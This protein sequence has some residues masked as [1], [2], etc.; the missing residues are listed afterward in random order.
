MLERKA[1][2]L[3]GYDLDDEKE[4]DDDYYDE[5]EDTD[6]RDTFEDQSNSTLLV[7]NVNLKPKNEP[8]QTKPVAVPDEGSGIHLHQ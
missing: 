3:R 7:T 8:S 5:E 1:K 4:E 6:N 2:G